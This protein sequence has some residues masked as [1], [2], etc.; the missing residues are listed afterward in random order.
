M[1]STT[2][3]VDEEEFLADRRLAEDFARRVV[4]SYG[5]EC[6]A[7]VFLPWSSGSPPPGVISPSAG[8]KAL[9]ME[10]V[11]RSIQGKSIIVFGCTF[12]YPE[13]R[14]DAALIVGQ[15][16]AFQT[17]CI[18][19]VHLLPPG[20]NYIR[21][22][23]DNLMQ[24]HA[25][26]GRIAGVADALLDPDWAPAKLKLRLKMAHRS[27]SA[28]QRLLASVVAD[29]PQPPPRHEIEALKAR[30]HQVLWKDIPRELMPRFPPMNPDLSETDEGIGD[31]ML[32]DKMPT[33]FGNVWEAKDKRGR[34]VVIKM[35]A[36]VDVFTPSEVEG[37]YREY[38]FLAGFLKHPH[39]V[40][41]IEAI[42]GPTRFYTVLQYAGKQNLVQYLS[43]RPGLRMDAKNAVCVFEK[44]ASAVAHCHSKDVSHRS[45]SLEHVV[46]RIED[47]AIFPQ[48]V[49]FRSAMISKKDVTSRT[50]C[51]SLPCI[52]PEVLK[53][54]PYSPKPCDFWSLGVLLLEMGG[55]KGS[56]FRAVQVDEEHG[57]DLPD[58]GHMRGVL[59]HQIQS[60]FVKRDNHQA[61]L[62][63]MGALQDSII[64]CILQSLLQPEDTRSTLQK[65][66]PADEPPADNEDPE[67]E[68][69][70]FWQ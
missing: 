18:L 49:D 29:E 63:C 53:G 20:S 68:A 70:A 66:L 9:D 67:A 28:N 42:H 16:K 47:G 61:A 35:M 32:T 54:G 30:Q 65:F 57:K 39:I 56:F 37:I 26:I 25:A 13:E 21:H 19:A 38:R 60:Y 48:L 52:A 24:T 58:D 22:N 4:E 36:K 6:L 46:V 51:G 11:N 64:L 8:Q 34:K 12:K 40:H 69:V 62:A 14:D 44:L 7:A 15:L 31:Y 2:E 43:D 33:Q 55:G 5:D 50:I 23:C 41:G 59:A 27:W 45:I 10:Q 1:Q 3:A 17:V